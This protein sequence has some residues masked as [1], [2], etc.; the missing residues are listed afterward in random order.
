MYNNIFYLLTVFFLGFIITFILTPIIAKIMKKFNKVGVDIHKLEKPGIP[1]ICGLSILI[2][3]ILTTA[4]LISFNTQN[5]LEYFSYIL[6]GIIAGMIGFYDDLASLGAN[7]KAILTAFACIP[8]LLLGTYH[9]HPILPF[10]GGVRLTIVY[11]ILLPFALAVPSNAVNMMDVFNGSMTGTCA[12]ISSTMIVCLLLVGKIQ[13]ALLATA[14]FGCLLA[15]YIYNKYPARVF[16]GDT[17]SLFIGASIGTLAIIGNIEVA[18]VV[19]LFPHIMNAFYG[20]ATVGKLYER[21]ELKSRPTKLL[22]NAKLDVTDEIK[23]PMTLARI[24]LARE[25]LEEYK[26]VRIMLILTMISSI[27]AIITQIIILV[28]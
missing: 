12:I 9:P 15:F 5:A 17:G 19:A 11:P 28:I 26:V 20:L 23:A 24:I 2:S 7:K 14:L 8:I 3:M 6:V 22:P 13:C 21:R 18:T 10:I 1:E 4:I 27:L 16:S 25:P